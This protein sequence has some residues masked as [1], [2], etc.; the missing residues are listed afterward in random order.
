MGDAL[1]VSEQVY[2]QLRRMVHCRLLPPEVLEA[3]EE[4]DHEGLREY[5]GTA[6]QVKPRRG[7]AT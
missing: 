3:I 6:V 2:G 1:F 5:V 7:R 4:D